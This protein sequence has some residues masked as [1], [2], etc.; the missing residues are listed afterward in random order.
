[1]SADHVA[2]GFSRLADRPSYELPLG[3]GSASALM[4]SPNGYCGTLEFAPGDAF[5]FHR[6]THQDEM[7]FVLEGMLEAWCGDERAMLHPGDT[8]VVPAGTVHAAFNSSDTV[9]KLLVLLNPLIP[10][11]DPDWEMIEGH[12]WE[13]VDVS[14]EEPW[15]SIR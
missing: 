6:H 11:V 14:E 3:M 15:S 5:G 13:M 9:L 12:G 2:P 4:G 8:M 7:L 10:G 1:M